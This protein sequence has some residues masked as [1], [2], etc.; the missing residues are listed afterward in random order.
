MIYITYQFTY[1]E[2]QNLI[3]HTVNVAKI[4]GYVKLH[5]HTLLLMMIA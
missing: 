3:Y 1:Q 4:T 2:S 5:I